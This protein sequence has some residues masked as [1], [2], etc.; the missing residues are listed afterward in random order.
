ME[1]GRQTNGL[2]LG[3]SSG[4]L[5]VGEV[6]IMKTKGGSCSTL[7]SVAV[8]NTTTNNVG[9]EGL[10]GLHVTAHPPERPGQESGGRNHGRALHTDLLS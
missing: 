7:V 8:I 1:E 2:L 9:R 5:T 4:D 3:D 10:F 6:R